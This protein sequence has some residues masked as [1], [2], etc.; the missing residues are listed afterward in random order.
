MRSPRDIVTAL[1][2][3]P[4]RQWERTL[5]GLTDQERREVAQFVT[6]NQHRKI[7]GRRLRADEITTIQEGMP[8]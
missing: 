7:G 8:Q 6:R 2:Q 1:R 5:K 3:T 4:R